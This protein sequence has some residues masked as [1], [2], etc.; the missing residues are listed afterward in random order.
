MRRGKTLQRMK[1]IRMY[2]VT[3]LAPLVF[4][5][6]TTVLLAMIYRRVR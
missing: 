5:I 4:M 6:S 2:P 3:P 1:E